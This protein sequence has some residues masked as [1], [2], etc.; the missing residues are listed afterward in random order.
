MNCPL[1]KKAAETASKVIDVVCD[2]LS[3]E[4]ENKKNKT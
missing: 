4:Q 3:G 2:R 1:L